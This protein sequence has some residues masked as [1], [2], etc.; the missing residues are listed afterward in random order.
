MAEKPTTIDE[1]IAAAPEE[2]RAQLAELREILSGVAPDATEEIKWGSPAYSRDRI[3]FSF[4]AS[5]KHLT[6]V[7]TRTGLEA[8]R[9][10]LEG[11]DTATDSVMFPWGE[12][13]PKE[14]IEKLARFRV[15]EVAG[16]GLWKH[17]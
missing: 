16:G 9:D 13:L 5:K 10:E 6:F 3:L 15:D 7:P 12:P 8:F 2:H 1:Y 17:S 14:L 4:K 11:Y